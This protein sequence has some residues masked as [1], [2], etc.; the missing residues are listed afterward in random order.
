LGHERTTRTDGPDSVNHDR[1]QVE[2]TLSYLAT[3]YSKYE[4]GIEAAFI[5]AS[6]LAARLIKSGVTVY[7]PIVYS[8]PVAIHGGI[9]PLDQ[10]FWY[11]FDQAMMEKCDVLI[12]A[13]M[14]GWE[15]STGI[16]HEVAFFQERWRPI[17][18]L[19]PVTLRM[20]KR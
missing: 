11:D 16:A 6:K 7:S 8:H 20:E 18:D 13:H 10:Q 9:D 5:E 15:Q 2:V 17:F 1:E 14:D 12:I 4:R 3:P 19:D